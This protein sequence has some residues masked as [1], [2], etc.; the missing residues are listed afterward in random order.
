LYLNSIFFSWK[1]G[2]L[3]LISGQSTYPH[4][5]YKT[6]M[7]GV[8]GLIKGSQKQVVGCQG[9]VDSRALELQEA[10]A[11]LSEI[12]R[13]SVS[14]VDEMIQSRFEATCHEDIGSKEDGL[15]PQEF[16]L[17]DVFT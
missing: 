6:I 15:W 5:V 11:I 10:K 16:Q 3:I 9:A 12:F 1:N 14:E 17:D 2:R 13:I 8:F 4:P 7:A